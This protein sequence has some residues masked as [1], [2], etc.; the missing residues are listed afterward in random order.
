M[1]RASEKQSLMLHNLM[2]AMHRTSTNDSSLDTHM[3]E[4]L[5]RQANALTE[6]KNNVVEADPDGEFTA[7]RLTLLEDASHRQLAILEDLVT[8]VQKLNTEKGSTEDRLH[9]LELIAVHQN[10]MLQDMHEAI[11]K[12]TTTPE[13]PKTTTNS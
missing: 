6:L 5:K 7:E 12:T 2:D 13:P 9:K 1:I 11:S 4:V 8:A 10:Q 3:E